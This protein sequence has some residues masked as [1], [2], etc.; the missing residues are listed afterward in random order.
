MLAWDGTI[1]I[2]ITLMKSE[3]SISQ[4]MGDRYY[5]ITGLFRISVTIIKIYLVSNRNCASTA[6]KKSSARPIS[7]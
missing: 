6:M 4:G 1:S 3:L 2:I 5:V 7:V